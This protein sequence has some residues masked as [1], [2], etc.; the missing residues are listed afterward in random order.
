MRLDGIGERV[1][2][3]SLITIRG[4]LIVT[5]HC[6]HNNHASSASI[7]RLR[8]GLL[9]RSLIIYYIYSIQLEPEGMRKSQDIPSGPV[10][11]LV[12]WC[13]AKITFPVEEAA[14]AK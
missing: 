4:S 6:L 1:D 3:N 8:Y 7:E 13:F 2:V 11:L 14:K 10:S 5:W 9:F 12:A